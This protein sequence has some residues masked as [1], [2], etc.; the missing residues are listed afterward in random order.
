MCKGKKGAAFLST[1]Y[2]NLALAYFNM[3]CLADAGAVLIARQGSG[4]E[5]GTHDHMLV[6]HHH[7][8]NCSASVTPNFCTSPV[9][10]LRIL[11]PVRRGIEE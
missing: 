10:L 2:S 5:L 3:Q 7:N 6:L 11:T 9:R 1:A 8:S 4:L